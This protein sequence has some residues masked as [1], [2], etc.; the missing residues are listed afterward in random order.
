MAFFALWSLLSLVLV[1]SV[2]TIAIRGALGG[3]NLS[4]G[5]RPARLD[6]S[7]FKDSGPAFDLF[8][9]SLRLF[10]QQNQSS[11]ISYYRVCGK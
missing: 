11:V 5:E 3:V 4:T 6:F 8:I 10:Q 9:Q 1:T 7:V 2:N